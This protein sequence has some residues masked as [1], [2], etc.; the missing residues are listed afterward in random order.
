MSSAAPKPRKSNTPLLAAI[1]LLMVGAAAFVLLRGNASSAPAAPVDLGF[2]PAADIDPG[3]L[4]PPAAG[5]GA[6]G[7]APATPAPSAVTV[8]AQPAVQQVAAQVPAATT[9][10]PSSGGIVEPVA[11]IA[12]AVTPPEPRAS[13]RDP[14]CDGLSD[15]QCELLLLDREAG[16]AQA[17]LDVLQTQKAI[18]D[19]SG[20]V[21]GARTGTNTL[22]VL[23]GLTGAGQSLQAEF[24]VGPRVFTARPGDWVTPEF[25]LERVLSNG[26]IVRRGE[27]GATHTMLMGGEVTQRATVPA[28]RPAAMPSPALH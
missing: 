12:L 28:G 27:R 20:E 18:A 17:Q 4:P 16:L 15:H 6:M 25:K 24:A 3:L 1:A 5:T 8:A 11:P 7:M 10:A 19:L 26:V 9:P 22:P 2:T 13:G 23:V 21:Q 14:E